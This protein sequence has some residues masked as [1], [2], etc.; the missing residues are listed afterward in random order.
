MRCSSP[1]RCTCGQLRQA[2]K[3][4]ESRIGLEKVRRIRPI[5]PKPPD[6]RLLFFE[7]GLIRRKP[8]R[9]ENNA[10]VKR[11]Q[12]KVLV[13]VI[14]GSTSDWETMEHTA[15]TLESWV[16][17]E[18]PVISA[19]ARRTCCSSTRHRSNADAV[20]IAGRRRGT[21]RGLPRPRHAAR[22]GVPIESKAL[23]GLDSLLSMVQMPEE[24]P[25]ERWRSESRSH[26]CRCS[27]RRFWESSTQSIGSGA[28]FRAAAIR[29][30]VGIRSL[31]R[32]PH[33]RR[34][35]SAEGRSTHKL[36]TRFHRRKL[37]VMNSKS[38]AFSSCSLTIFSS[39]APAQQHAV[40]GS[41]AVRRQFLLNGK[42]SR[43][44]PVRSLRA[45]RAPTGVDR[46]RM[47]KAM[48]LT[49][50]HLCFL[51]RMNP[52]PRLRFLRQ[53]RR[54]RI[55]SRSDRRPVRHL[56]P[57]PYACAEWEFGI[58]RLVLKIVHRRSQPIPKF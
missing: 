41:F 42:P 20:I 44:F 7:R 1:D 9:H 26:Q 35:R 52:A 17:V 27:R 53:Q 36:A 49:P 45:L 51:E 24:F 58:S 21:L 6:G 2:W 5:D 18:T 40:P 39:A 13:G 12:Q 28:E 34:T 32:K 37:G 48:G 55:H 47:A 46:F 57:R 19:H 23:K 22:S 30:S 11:K 8:K 3:Q 54:R 16:A 29:E 56:A 33:D 43:S 4:R 10:S 38:C 25:W 15:K 50:H 14:M 31:K